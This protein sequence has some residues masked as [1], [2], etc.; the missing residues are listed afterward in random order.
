MFKCIG[1]LLRDLTLRW[2]SVGS[3]ELSLTNILCS[4]FANEIYFSVSLNNISSL[5]III[6]LVVAEKGLQ[7]GRQS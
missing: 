5:P 2:Q 6:V 4:R 3:E 1:V 7:S